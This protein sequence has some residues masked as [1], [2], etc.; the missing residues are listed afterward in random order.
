MLRSQKFSWRLAFGVATV[1]VAG[2]SLPFAL[3]VGALTSTPEMI[4]DIGSGTD[5]LTQSGGDISEI[6]TDGDTAYFAASST[7]DGSPDGHGLWKS[8]GTASGTVQIASQTQLAGSGIDNFVKVGSN[9]Y[10]T[11]IGSGGTGTLVKKYDGTS[12]STVV[13]RTDIQ[14]AVSGAGNADDYVID[15]SFLWG[16]GGFVYFVATSTTT[17]NFRYDL[18]KTDG[19]TV[20]RATSLEQEDA[21][22]FGPVF[23]LDETTYYFSY[24]ANAT[25]EYAFDT[26]PSTGRRTTTIRL[27]SDAADIVH[28]VP[29][30][31]VIL[32]G[33][34]DRAYF[35]MNTGHP[36]GST[37]VVT[38]DGTTVSPVT[39]G[40][41]RIRYASYPF[42]A[43][44]RVY[45]PGADDELDDSLWY[46]TGTN[47]TEIRP[48]QSWSI[49]SFSSKVF[50]SVG[51]TYLFLQRG[52]TN[53]ELWRSD[54]TDDGT[55]LLADL[56]IASNFSLNSV[57]WLY[58]AQGE[59]FFPS[60]SDAD[61]SIRV[62]KTD[63]TQSGTSAPF[64]L[65]PS[66]I[67]PT[68][69]AEGLNT[70][71][72]YAETSG[73]G[74]ELHGAVPSVGTPPQNPENNNPNTD[75]GNTNTGGGTSSGGNT[76]SSNSTT[77]VLPSVTEVSSFKTV[78]LVPGGSV[79]AGQSFEVTADG[80]QASEGVN[81]YLQGSTTSIGVSKASVTGTAEVTVK[82]PKNTTGKKTLYLF[83]KSS[84]HGVKQT[85]VVQGSVTELPATGSQPQILLWAAI[86]M[87]FGGFGLR[88]SRRLS[89]R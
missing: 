14:T 20:T 35:L 53:F 62:R 52:S 56:G 66:V 58:A 28:S 41:V 89:R 1:L 67:N 7:H 25:A 71:F 70:V 12:V 33:S 82:I 78:E 10:F 2:V 38:F 3:H 68:R 6:F 69:F 45:F 36:E 73:S 42:V 87:I 88:R 23:E 37:Q 48:S 11:V 75:N 34:P 15:A 64:D 61:A 9:I 55:F 5:D 79:I 44:N 57:A 86:T 46:T 83:G 81:A 19:T 22:N 49:P 59:I 84:R 16:V 4:K 18:F 30:N 72:F 63:G 74:I 13:A 54:G 17:P 26:M 65:T 60:A 39:N 47:A 51:S 24:Q 8:D 21:S 40:T 50:G 32:P 80:F 77:N 31:I 27:A 85:I 43:G 29:Q 76:A